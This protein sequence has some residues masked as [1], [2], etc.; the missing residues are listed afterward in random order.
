VK[1]KETAVRPGKVVFLPDGYAE[2]WH[3][4]GD[5]T[6][7]AKLYQFKET[8]MQDSYFRSTPTTNQLE[9]LEDAGL[10]VLY[11]KDKDIDNDPITF[12]TS[13]SAD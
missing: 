13:W 10:L 11:D 7:L 12:H 6:H 1:L 8:A 9:E 5:V 4:I 2:V 3:V